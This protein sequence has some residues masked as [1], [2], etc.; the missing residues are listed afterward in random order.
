[1]N[2]IIRPLEVSDA[3]LSYR[4][5]ND[6]EIWIYTGNKP[7]K[8]ITLEIEQEWIRNVLKRQNE[9]RFAICIGDKM[10]Y[11]GNVQLTDIIGTRAQ[12]HIFIGVKK[13][14]GLGIGTKATKLIL[15]YGFDILRLNEVYLKVNKFNI[16]AIK[17]YEKCGF[18]IVS[19]VENE[20]T[21]SIFRYD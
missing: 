18:E 4:W 21:M 9:K 2:V 19:K 17:S 5:R 3:L 8:E 10:E 16:S 13:Y 6:N 12:L 20:F 11:V 14:L 7:N 15:D 1:M